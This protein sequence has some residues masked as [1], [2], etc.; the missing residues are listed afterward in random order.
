MLKL[1]FKLKILLVTKKKKLKILLKLEIFVKLKQI[2]SFYF[3]SL[4]L[5]KKCETLFLNGGDNL[6]P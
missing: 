3:N 6:C 5:T 2:E 4:R 1:I